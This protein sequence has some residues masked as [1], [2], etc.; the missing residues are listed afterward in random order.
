MGLLRHPLPPHL[1]TIHQNIALLF[2]SFNKHISCCFLKDPHQSLEQESFLCA[3]L[4]PLYAHIPLSLQVHL[5]SKP[6]PLALISSTCP[7]PSNPCCGLSPFM[8]SRLFSPEGSYPSS[9]EHLE[10]ILLF[11]CLTWPK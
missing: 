8:R 5:H 4:S 10:N 2:L 9:K 1:T 3:P 7:L 11:P 6:F